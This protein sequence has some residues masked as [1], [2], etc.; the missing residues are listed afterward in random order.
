MVADDRDGW[1]DRRD[2]C[3]AA[4]MLC[5]CQYSQALAMVATNSTTFSIR[6]I[7]ILLNTVTLV[8]VK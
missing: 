3:P 7:F 4:C 1:V 5:T 2:L 8:Y 6:I